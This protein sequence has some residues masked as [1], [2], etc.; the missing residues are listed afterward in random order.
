MEE[1]RDIGQ[2]LKR[3]ISGV[4]GGT[5]LLVWA[6]H[7][8]DLIYTVLNFDS[9]TVLQDKILAI[10]KILSEKRLYGL[11]FCPVF[12]ALVSVFF[13]YV[14]TYITYA[15]TYFFKL[16]VQPFI[17]KRVDRSKVVEK[18]RYDKLSQQFFQL[19]NDYNADKAEFIR[20]RDDNQ[21]LSKENSTLV[22]NISERNS[23]NENLKNALA[24]LDIELKGTYDK[25]LSALEELIKLRDS[26]IYDLKVNSALDEKEIMPDVLFSG[27]WQKKFTPAGGQEGKENFTVIDGKYI[28]NQKVF[29]VF[30]YVKIFQ[31]D[32]MIEFSKRSVANSSTLLNR[33]VKVSDNL[34]VGV[35]NSNI[36]VEYIRMK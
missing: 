10:N 24:K 16:R 27:K 11:L 26:E 31:Q 13:F 23:E 8:W 18:V 3:R 6:I 19:D 34:Y 22:L 20:G 4:F 5:F 32:T 7:N 17:L 21:R 36:K 9:G 12:I 30:D 2:T 35:E 1:I 33:L 28:I 25:K 15:I 14:F 29:F